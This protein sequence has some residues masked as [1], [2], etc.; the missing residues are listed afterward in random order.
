MKEGCNVCNPLPEAWFSF[1]FFSALQSAQ[2]SSLWEILSRIKFETQPRC[3]LSSTG[4]DA[5]TFGH[6][7]HVVQDNGQEEYE[8]DGYQEDGAEASPDWTLHRCISPLDFLHICR[9]KMFGLSR[10]FWVFEA[11]SVGVFIQW[12][13][14]QIAAAIG[15]LDKNGCMCQGDGWE[16]F[17]V[18]WKLEH[19][20][21]SEM[22]YM[23]APRAADFSVI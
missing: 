9:W 15:Q 7:R 22:C 14:K 2:L 3:H 23:A 5:E 18:V 19:G 4:N 16:C 17:R 12:K 11:V 8:D 10:P 13:R 1:P 20:E 21:A 6:T